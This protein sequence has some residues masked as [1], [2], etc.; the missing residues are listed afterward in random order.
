M[1]F[2]RATKAQSK[3]RLAIFGPSGAGK[4]FSALRIAVGMGGGIAVIDTERGS[5][6]KYADR[7]AFDVLDLTAHGVDKYVAAIDAAARA[8][9]NVLIIDSLSH[10]WR[11][12]VEEVD[13]IAKAKYNSNTWAAWREGNP[14]QLAL[15]NAILNFPGHVIA[16][17]RSKTEWVIETSDRGKAVPKRVGLSPEQGKGIE[18]EFDMMIEMSPEHFGVVTKD[19]TGQ[20]Q[21]KAL[22]RPGEE[23]GRE[24]L[25]WLSQ[26]EVPQPTKSIAPVNREAEAV[27]AGEFIKSLGIQKADFELFRRECADKGANWIDIAL[28]AR[29]LTVDNFAGL[30]AC[31]EAG[32][33]VA[34]N[35]EKVYQAS[36]SGEEVI[37]NNDKAHRASGSDSLRFEPDEV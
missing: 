32:E 25:E 37:A 21:D 31:I 23:F 27:E 35:K 22:E 34:E 16:T 30:M 6:S 15:V 9:Y 5:A 11:E 3:L 18:Y 12:L 13:R 1:Q 19:R 36:A 14:K 29:W 8:G 7:F 24:L 17:M 2:V 26:G 20:F 28:G 4:T 33:E 10:G